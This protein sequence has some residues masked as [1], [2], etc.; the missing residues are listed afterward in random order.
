MALYSKFYYNE[1]IRKYVVAF[2]S[3]FSNIHVVRKNSER[4]EIQREI[5]P[6]TYAPK[7][8]FIQRLLQDKNEDTKVAIKLP[9]LAFEINNF[10]YDTERK[11]TS[12]RRISQNDPNN[13]SKSFFY[14]PVPYN[15]DFSLYLFTKTQEEGLQIIE[16]IAPFFTPDYTL[17]LKLTTLDEYKQDIPITLT[18][19]TNE[20]SY[21]GSFEERRSI[22]WTLTFVLKGYLIGPMRQQSRVLSSSVSS[23]LVDN[24]EQAIIAEER[25]TFTEVSASTN[26][27]NTTTFDDYISFD[28]DADNPQI[29]VYRGKTLSLDIRAVDSNGNPF[30]FSNGTLIGKFRTNFA[31]PAPVFF[32][33]SVVKDNFIRATIDSTITQNMLNDIYIFDI[34]FETATES[35]LVLDGTFI[36]K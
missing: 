24:I 31:D 21:E 10:Q 34:Y 25:K 30:D 5:V 13:T 2:G 20:D 23:I 1:V 28:N 16:Q 29:T 19:I 26:I 6:L 4:A 3:L 14:N 27:G 36:V 11:I 9:H 15:F 12:K 22:I 18:S 33:V 35:I 7:E 17:T 32:D 8:K